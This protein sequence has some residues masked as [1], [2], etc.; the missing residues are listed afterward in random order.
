MDIELDIGSNF[1][2]DRTIAALRLQR[3]GSSSLPIGGDEVYLGGCLR[4]Q[5]RAF[6]QPLMSCTGRGRLTGVV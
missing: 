1:W 4:G 3:Y 2:S 5:F 6:T